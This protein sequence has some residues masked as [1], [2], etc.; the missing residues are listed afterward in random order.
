MVPSLYFSPR[1]S[2]LLAHSSIRSGTKIYLCGPKAEQWYPGHS[3][4]SA[5]LTMKRKQPQLI[6]NPC[7]HVCVLTMGGRDGRPQKAPPY[8]CSFLCLLTGWRCKKS[9]KNYGKQTNL[10]RRRTNIFSSISDSISSLSWVKKE[11]TTRENQKTSTWQYSFKAF[12]LPWCIVF[13][14]KHQY[15]VWMGG[16]HH[17]HNVMHLKWTQAT[18]LANTAFTLHIKNTPSDKHFQ[19]KQTKQK[20]KNLCGV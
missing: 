11:K 10:Q 19:G 16:K 2:T 4:A 8:L 7:P 14:W 18:Q 12:P 20:L 13:L 15:R 5:T 1:R 3:R 9:F 6:G 17:L